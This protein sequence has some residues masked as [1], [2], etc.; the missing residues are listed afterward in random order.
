M[1][2]VPFYDRSELIEATVDTLRHALLEEIILVTLAHIVFLMHFRS[3]LV[4]TLPLP[5]AVLCSFLLMHYT[6]ITSNVMSLAGIAIAIGVLVDAGIVVTENAFRH[7]EGVDTHDRRRVLE[8]ILRA[9]KLVGRP[10]F[11]SMAIIVLA[12]VPV[13]AL[14]GQ[15]GKL[16]HPLAFAK[17]FAMASAT[18]ISL[19]LIPILCT[20]LLRG[21][22]SENRNPVMRL[23]Q[24]LYRPALAWALDHRM[25]TLTGALVLFGGA[26]VLAS[27][28]GSEFMPPASSAI[29][30]GLCFRLLEIL[31]RNAALVPLSL[32]L[33]LFFPLPGH[34]AGTHYCSTLTP[35][36]TRGYNR[37]PGKSNIQ[38]GP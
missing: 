13:F 37:P 9:T 35:L 15:E 26:V 33:H 1:R 16:F 18:A 24:R 34:C 28:I 32:A 20:V 7:L 21:G 19:T 17:S 38:A 6:H 23:L 12:F 11:F 36:I 31:D 30:L 14:T 10:T 29:L 22:H 27:G 8:T 4:V 5:L 3:I 2:I 25:I